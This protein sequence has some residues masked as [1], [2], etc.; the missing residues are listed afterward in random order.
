MTL[1]RYHNLEAE[2]VITLG[3]YPA[4]MK[5]FIIVCVCYVKVHVLITKIIIIDDVY[6]VYSMYDVQVHVHI[7]FHCKVYVVYNYMYI[8]SP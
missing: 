7:I 2:I 1:S 5:C 6:H 8:M 3:Y 4:C